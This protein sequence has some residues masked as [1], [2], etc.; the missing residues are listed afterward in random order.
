M[1]KEKKSKDSSPQ[2]N[3]SA[4]YKTINKIFLAIDKTLGDTLEG[5]QAT[6]QEVELAIAMLN[7]KLKTHEMT[8]FFDQVVSE[9]FERKKAEEP[10]VKP[11]FIK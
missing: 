7:Y 11:D 8:A 2:S 5:T 1:S 6:P 3:E 4:S 10:N 9:Y